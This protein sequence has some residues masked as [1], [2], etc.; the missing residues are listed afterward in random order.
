MIS[1]HR[2]KSKI[3]AF[4]LA[5]LT[6]AVFSVIS[7]IMFLLNIHSAVALEQELRCG[8]DEHVHTDGCYKGDFLC[9]GKVAHVHDG[10]CYIV[11]LS[12]NNVNTVLDMSEGSS[13]E[14]VIDDVVTLARDDNS[15]E[16]SR[17]E[18]TLINSRI[19]DDDS[20]PDLVLNDD[21]NTVTTVMQEQEKEQQEQQ[22]TPGQINVENIPSGNTSYFAVGD[23]PDTGN[24]NANFYVFLDGEWTCI[25][26]LDYTTERQST[27]YQNYVIPTSDVLAL[28]NGALGTSYDYNDFAI[29]VS[30]SASRN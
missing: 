14:N 30:T 6:L 24:Y 28:V 7:C 18:V 17:D 3:K 22:G 13:L 5:V 19:S 27:R 26:T 1:P 4:F 21:I 11:L 8:I 15:A 10:N 25:G 29:S 2:K 9:C 20:A 16:W 12:D 23:D